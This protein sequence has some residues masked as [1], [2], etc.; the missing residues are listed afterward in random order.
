METT[1]QANAKADSQPQ[2]E[3]DALIQVPPHAIADAAFQRPKVSVCMPASRNIPWFQQALRSVLIQSLRDIEIVITDD[4]GGDLSAVVD[5][6]ADPRVR[7]YPNPTRLGFSGNHCRAIDLTTGDY[8]AFLHDDDEWEADYLSSASEVLEK[9]PEVGLVLCGA[10]EID[11]RDNV[12]GLRPARMNPGVQPDPL[13]SFLRPDFMLMLPS[14]ALF[15]RTALETNKRPWPNVVA[16]DA[17]MFIDV[18]RG[19]WKVHYIACPLVH[20]RIHNQQ[21]ALDDLAHRHALVTVWSGYTFFEDHF[22]L[23]R[24]KILAQCLIARAGAWLRRGN[25]QAARQ[26]LV[27]ARHTDASTSQIRWLVLRAATIAPFLLPPLLKLREWLPRKH[28]H[29]GT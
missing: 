19:D 2:R 11:G 13:G 18:V 22:E 25:C 28:R 10:Q 1:V 14:V 5:G 16:G 26:D 4:S 17:T 24:K 3:A 7:Y 15:R 23:Q 21:I 6:F 9:N 29:E 12:I 8:L 27:E 20:Y